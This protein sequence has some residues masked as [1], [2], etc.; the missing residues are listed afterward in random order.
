MLILVLVVGRLAIRF[1]EILITDRLIEFSACNVH[2]KDKVLDKHICKSR[3]LLMV[4]DQMVVRRNGTQHHPKS[5][6]V[7]NASVYL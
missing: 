2:G 1:R 3:S 5:V 4:F 6:F 7:F